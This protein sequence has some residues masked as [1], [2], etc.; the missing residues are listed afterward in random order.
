ML[1]RRIR[2]S[3]VPMLLISIAINIG[4]Y[5]ERFL[6]IATTQVRQYLPDRWGT[7]VP[8]LVEISIIVGSLAMFITLFLVFVKILP[9]I[10]IYEIKET[11]DP[12]KKGKPEWQATQ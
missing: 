1:S 8:S 12:P 2:T 5:T 3:F 9:S 7:Y 11:M 6:I 10:S 4:M